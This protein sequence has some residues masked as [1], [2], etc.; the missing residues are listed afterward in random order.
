MT[1]EMRKDIAL[2]IISPAIGLCGSVKPEKQ[3]MAAIDALLE[4]YDLVIRGNSK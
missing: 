4:K 1:P 2:K 3:A